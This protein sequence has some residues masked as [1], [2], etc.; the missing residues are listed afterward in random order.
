MTLCFAVHRSSQ[1]DRV[2][3]SLAPDHTALDRL[4]STIGSMPDAAGS[5]FHS[6]YSPVSG[7]AALQQ[8][9]ALLQRLLEEE[10]EHSKASAARAEQLGI[11]K[12]GA[13]G[14]T[15]SLQKLIAESLD[16]LESRRVAVSF[17][18]IAVTAVF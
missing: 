12:Q 17:V 7:V 11:D 15:R 2:L 3:Q 10:K 6:V 4:G 9:N 8:E 13:I 18:V 5:P 1:A 16:Q 14:Q